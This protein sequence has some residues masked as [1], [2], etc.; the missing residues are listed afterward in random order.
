MK[1]ASKPLAVLGLFVMTLVAFMNPVNAGENSCINL[2]ENPK[3]KFVFILTENTP[4]KDISDYARTD[5]QLFGK[6]IAQQIC[7][8]DHTY[9]L[10]SASN[11]NR[12]TI[13][14]P[15]I[16]SAINKMKQYYK[17]AVRKQKMDLNQVNEAFSILLIKAYVC[18][19][20]ETVEIESLLSEAKTPEAIKQVFDCIE[21]KTTN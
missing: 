20:E 9:V 11:D 13:I 1:K 10:F 17:D 7:L 3:G 16:Y 21:I 8:I 19:Y 15:V 4:W 5:M 14:K 6:E 12:P 18:Y 2:N